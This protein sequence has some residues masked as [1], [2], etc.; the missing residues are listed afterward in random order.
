MI[1]NYAQVKLSRTDG[2][3]WDLVLAEHGVKAATNARDMSRQLTRSAATDYVEV[4]LEQRD[5]ANTVDTATY[6]W[7]RVTGWATV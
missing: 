4:T 6:R 5:G 7:S 3:S 1:A 2:R